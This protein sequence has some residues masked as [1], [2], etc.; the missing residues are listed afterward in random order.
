LSLK[1][2]DTRIYEPQI[3]ARLGITAQFCNAGVLTLQVLDAMDK[4]WRTSNANVHRGAHA[5]SV[6]ATDQYEGARD[7]VVPPALTIRPID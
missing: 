3:R 7:K 4:Y 6:K 1:L 5:L 2:S